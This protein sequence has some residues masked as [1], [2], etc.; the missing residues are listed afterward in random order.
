MQTMK[1]PWHLFENISKYGTNVGPILTSVD[2]PSNYLKYRKY[3]AHIIQIS[4]KYCANIGK[5]LSSF[6]IPDFLYQ[7][8]LSLEFFLYS[9]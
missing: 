1:S 7:P 5:I 8:L 4:D 6:D 3:C 2:I 9:L